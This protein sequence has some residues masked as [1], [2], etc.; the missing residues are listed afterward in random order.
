LNNESATSAALVMKTLF[1][2]ESFSI[3][4][5]YAVER[6]IKPERQATNNDHKTI[7]IMGAQ[8]KDIGISRAESIIKNLSVHS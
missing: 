1:A 8:M 2:L 3:T 5:P 7:V 6:K 4:V